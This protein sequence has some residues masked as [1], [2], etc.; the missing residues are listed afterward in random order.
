[1]PDKAAGATS[2]KVDIAVAGAGPSGMACAILL[3]RHGF[4]TALIAPLA[5]VDD[6]RTTALLDSSVEM[7]KSLGLW[8]A[9]LPHAAALAHMRIIDATGRLIRAP[10]VVFDAS[11]LQLEAF[12]YNIENRHLNAVLAG[13]CMAEENLQRIDA[14]VVDVAAHEATAAISLDNGAMVEARLVVGADGRRSKV[15]EAAGIA[16]SEWRYPQSALVLNLEHLAPHYNHSSEFHTRTGPFT[17]VPLPGRRSSLVCVV[18]PETAETLSL[19]SDEELALELE[20][21]AHS[22]LGV[23]KVIGKRQCYP[24]GGLTAKTVAANRTALIG[25]AAHVFPPIGAQGLNMGLRDVAALG[26]IVVSAQASGQDIGGPGVLT[27][28]ERARRPDIVSRTTGVDLL[29]RSLLSDLLPVQL[30][31]SVGLYLAGRIGPLRRVLMREGIAPMM[32][33]P[34]LM[35][36]L[37]LR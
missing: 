17:L 35:R 29:N 10:E 3:A 4:S 34:K 26:E 11:E 32:A 20:R 18:E 7:L 2:I 30:M 16:V 25:E 22:I 23:M 12:G 24:L 31:R 14:R 37:S 27:A 1:M 9:I 33:R 19:M 8:D 36:G 5:P 15:R 6:G 21:R 28:Y 13:A